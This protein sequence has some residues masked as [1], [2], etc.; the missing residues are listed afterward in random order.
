MKVK[1]T[2]QVYG[3]GHGGKGDDCVEGVTVSPEGR[4]VDHK[5]DKKHR[6]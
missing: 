4:D 5:Y 2:M 1:V 6:S 3:G